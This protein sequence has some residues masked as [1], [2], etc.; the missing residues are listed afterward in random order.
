MKA[1]VFA[2]T[3]DP[4]TNGHV[5][6]INECLKMFDKVFVAVGVNRDKKPQFTLEERINLIKE[7]YLDNPNVVVK[8]FEGMLTDFMKREGI[9]FNV[10]GIRDEKD[11]E[12]EAKMNKF[13]S[14]MFPELTTIFLPTP[15]KLEHLS[16]SAVRNILSYDK[17][18][19]LYV[20]KAVSKL[21]EEKK[22]AK[23]V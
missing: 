17:E 4:I 13:N 15:A 14:E 6:V 16:S 10:R 20:P 11:Y 12:Y 8:E 3:F 18:I 21:I 2:G 5:Y 19:D 22:K 9:T 7:T 1:C 23:K